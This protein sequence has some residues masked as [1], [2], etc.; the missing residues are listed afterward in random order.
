MSYLMKCEKGRALTYGRRIPLTSGAHRFN[1]QWR[2]VKG[3]VE[4]NP[5]G[6]VILYKRESAL[7]RLISADRECERHFIARAIRCHG[8]EWDREYSYWIDRT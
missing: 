6:G 4:V 3:Q 5:S 7:G 2:S 8:G 1:V